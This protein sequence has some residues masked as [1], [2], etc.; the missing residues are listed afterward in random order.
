MRDAEVRQLG[1]AVVRDE[2]VRGLDVARWMIL[3]AWR[4]RA[5][6]AKL[7][8][9]PPSADSRGKVDCSS[10]ASRL[11]PDT[12]SMTMYISPLSASSPKS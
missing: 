7:A 9:D 12:Y 6:A 11:D 3:F 10:I 4:H 8:D 1:R 2:D 5:L